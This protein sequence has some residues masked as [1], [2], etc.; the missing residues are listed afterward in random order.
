MILS[1][2][3]GSLML[4]G[5]AAMLLLIIGWLQRGL[6]LHRE[7]AAEKR[8]VAAQRKTEILC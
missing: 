1:I 3:S 8:P 5:P 2:L 4:G 6:A 7:K